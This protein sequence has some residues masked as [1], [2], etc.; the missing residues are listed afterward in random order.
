M[1]NQNRS[2]F[3]IMPLLT[4]VAVLLV[5]GCKPAAQSTAALRATRASQATAKPQDVPTDTPTPTSTATATP[6]PTPTFTATST[7]T[8]TPT[9][10]STLVPVV[11]API[12]TAEFRPQASLLGVAMEGYTYPLGLQKALNLNVR[13]VRRWQ[14]IMWRDVEAVE[15]QYDWS[16]LAGL[17]DELT[18]AR[19]VGIQ[20][21][22]TIQLSPAWAQKV[23]NYACGPIRQDKFEAFAAFMEQLVQRYGS[24]TPYRVRYWQIGNELDLAPE[25]TVFDNIYGCWGDLNDPGYGGGYYAEMLKVVYPRLKAADPNARLMIGGLLLECDPYNADPCTNER[26]KKSGYFLQGVMD[27]GGGD[28]FDYVD[29]H[30]YAEFRSDLPSKMHSFYDW[31]GPLGGTGLP[32][33]VAFA[34]QVMA[35]KGYNKP[36]FIGE[37]ALKCK[38]PAGECLDASAAFV[39]RVYAEAYRLGVVGQVYY[40]LVADSANYAL[41]KSDLTPRPMYES[42]KVLSDNLHSA[43]F[44]RLVTDYPG[45]SGSEFNQNGTRLFQI[46]WSSDGTDRTISTPAGFIRATDKFGQL[47]E[48]VNGQLTIGWSPIYIDVQ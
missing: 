34:R 10:T 2:F 9:A 13:F 33:K 32:E 16:K 27:A 1:L 24:A 7:E 11:H 41:L 35:Q 28:Y 44:E 5:T 12:I 8:P 15:G 17:E 31:S 6:T 26:R 22:V 37:V 36:V 43:R 25:E 38:E 19:A 4:L 30:S 48:P 47:I 21:I 39:P 45:V 29:V 3:G 18:A 23:P 40:L 46:V 20:P 42:Y 14:P